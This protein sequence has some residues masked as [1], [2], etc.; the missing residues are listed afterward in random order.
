MTF[1][2]PFSYAVEAYNSSTKRKEEKFD[3]QKSGDD[4]DSGPPAALRKWQRQ[5]P[6]S[7]FTFESDEP[8]KFYDEMKFS[9]S[10]TKQSEKPTGYD[11]ILCTVVSVVLR[12][13]L[14]AISNSNLLSD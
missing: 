6:R 11:V 10:A 12:S 8:R 3:E 1:C 13:D 4:S 7:E 14:V 9:S 5:R 2:P